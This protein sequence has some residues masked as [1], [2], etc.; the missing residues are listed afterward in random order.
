MHG[1]QT[2]SEEAAVYRPEH[3]AS[4][5]WTEASA[6]PVEDARGLPGALI[7]FNDAFFPCPHS[8]VAINEGNTW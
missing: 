7:C 8:S 4:I 1:T 6:L 3:S 5:D 2:Q